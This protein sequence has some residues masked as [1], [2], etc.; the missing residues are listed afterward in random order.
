[1]VLSGVGFMVCPS[2]SALSE[3]GVRI[4][5]MYR[6]HPVS[7]L[8]GTAPHVAVRRCVCGRKGTQEF[9]MLPSW[10]T[11][12]YLGYGF[13]EIISTGKKHPSCHSTLEIRTQSPHQG[14]LISRDITRD[15]DLKAK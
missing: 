13:L 3:V 14:Y 10:S 12:L 8:E 4:C 11:S 9:P 7:L 15:I 2:P 6:S 5:L 1:M